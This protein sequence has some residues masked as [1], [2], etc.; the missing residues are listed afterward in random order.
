MTQLVVSLLPARDPSACK[1]DPAMCLS[2]D[3]DDTSC[4]SACS[5]SM[6]DPPGCKSDPA[7]G[8]AMD[9]DEGVACSALC[10]SLLRA[11]LSLVAAGSHVVCRPPPC[12]PTALEST[13]LADGQPA[14]ASAYPCSRCLGCKRKSSMHRWYRACLVVSSGFVSVSAIRIEK[15]DD[16]GY[17]RQLH[18][19]RCAKNGQCQASPAW[20]TYQPTGA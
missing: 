19:Q 1:S 15:Q 3:D 18:Q 8:V 5:A 6:T 2:M 12:K 11:C 17:G 10:L 7:M 14:H 9:D 4:E 16:S 20:H 13:V